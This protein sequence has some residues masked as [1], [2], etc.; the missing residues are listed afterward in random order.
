MAIETITATP[1]S[2]PR[3]RVRRGAIPLGL[4]ALGFVVSFAG[5]WIPSLWGDEAASVLSAERPLPSL[6]AMLTRIDAVHGTYYLLLHQWVAVFGASEL[7][8]RL[9]SALAAGAAVAGTYFVARRLTTRRVAILAG[10]VCAVLPRMTYIGE[11]ARGYA[12]ATAIATWLT[13]LLL[14]LVDRRTTSRLAWVAYAVLL[15]VGIY[16]FLYLFLVAI[17][18]GVYVAI[19]HRSRIRRWLV[20][21]AAGLAAAA[22]V[23]IFGFLER[24][25]VAFIKNRPVT[26]GEVLVT[27]WFDNPWLA[28]ACWA[29]IVAAVIAAVRSRR[30]GV[31]T[32]ALPWLIVPTLALLSASVLIIPTYTLRYVS[33]STPA[34]A[35]LVAAGLALLRPQAV[36]IAGL[37]LLVALAAPSYVAQR[38]DYAKG[39]GSDWRQ[40]SA[41]I[42]SEAHPGDAV[43]FDNSVRASR[44]PRLALRMYPDDYRGL[45]DVELAVPFGESPGLWDQTT[46][47]AQNATKLT[48]VS[49][50]WLLTRAGS[51]DDVNGNDLH[52]LIALG[53]SLQHKTHVHTTNIYELTRP[54]P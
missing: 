16:V 26:A 38:T 36:L 44:K 14:E 51:T 54:L 20:A 8:V 25:Q 41:L 9:P 39:A 30:A 12:L 1:I 21:T 34:A 15:A 19:S 52:E 45:V 22:P 46:P 49:T 53:F 17:A 47:L 28:G 33:L 7:S 32:L 4:A 18:H 10:I 2:V 13:V 40:A 35:I 48:G 6:F 24:H 23:A 42:A 3:I 11:E 5:S 43:L 37:G 31:V 29:L 50:V 27:Q